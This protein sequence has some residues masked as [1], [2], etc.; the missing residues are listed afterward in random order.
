[1]RVVFSYFVPTRVPPWPFYSIKPLCLTFH[2]DYA[3]T[4]AKQGP[5]LEDGS[6]KIAELEALVKQRD[7]EVAVLLAKLKHEREI[8]RAQAS[9]GSG[10]SRASTDDNG[11]DRQPR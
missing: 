3:Q 11:H 4:L 5:S 1:M 10:S 9:G 2:L 6:S 7:H 8:N